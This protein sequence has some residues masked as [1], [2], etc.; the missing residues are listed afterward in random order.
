[1]KLS[2]WANI[3]EIVSAVAIIGSL[4]YIAVQIDQNTGAI[5]AST[6]QD[7]LSYG[8]EQAELLI[9]Q[10]GLAQFVIEAEQDA[11]NLT[12][13]EKLRF[14][15]F[16]SW[17]FA[18]WEIAHAAYVDGIM[19]EEMWLA[20]DGYYRLIIEGKPGYILFFENTRPQWDSRFMKHVDEIV[21]SRN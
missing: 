12:D 21:N 17:R 3:G 19:S 7:V 20:W 10:P 8:R 11:K 14:Y 4:I 16:T 5:Q 13:E 6:Q 2:E 18:T 1:M 15:E 9:T